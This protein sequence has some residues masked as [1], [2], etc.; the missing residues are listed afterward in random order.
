[1]QILLD[2][3]AKGASFFAEV[4]R[5]FEGGEKLRFLGVEWFV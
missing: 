3:T 5:R 2:L 4:L 1:M